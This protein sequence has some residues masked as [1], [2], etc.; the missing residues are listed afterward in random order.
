MSVRLHGEFV[1]MY[2]ADRMAYRIDFFLSVLA[3]GLFQFTG[4]LFVG[5]IYSQELTFPGWTFAQV[6]LL[7][8]IVSLIQG[9]S[10]MNFFGL[11][12]NTEDLVKSGKFDLLLI[13]PVNTLWLLVMDSFDG[14]DIG[15]V[16]GALTIIGIAIYLIKGL[17]GSIVLFILLITLGLLFYFSL[18]VI[19]SALAILFTRVRRLYEFINIMKMFA[20]YPQSIYSKKLSIAFTIF[21]PLFIAG[22]YP[23]AALLGFPLNGAFLACVATLIWAASCVTFWHYSLKRY[24]G[25]GG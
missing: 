7:Q 12:W 17:T 21:F 19:C 1:K 24:T 16:L 6:L 15:Q 13:K 5:V 25:A 20:S 2:Y 4:P 18:A 11:L 3:M 14:E 8:G 10:F 9:L 22:N 23:A